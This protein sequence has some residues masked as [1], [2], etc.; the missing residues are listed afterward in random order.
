MDYKI[1]PQHE[2]ISKIWKKQK[3]SKTPFHF[4]GFA[5]DFM[6]RE[7]CLINIHWALTDMLSLLQV[8]YTVQAFM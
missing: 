5:R 2:N 8:Q 6:L 1:T 7:L 3:V 4:W